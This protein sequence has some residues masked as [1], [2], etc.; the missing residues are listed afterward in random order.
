MEDQKKMFLAPKN[1]IEK[2]AIN[3]LKTPVVGFDT[4]SIVKDSH[5]KIWLN[6]K[7]G[8]R[9]ALGELYDEYIELLYSYGMSISKDRAHVMDCI[10]D[11]FIDLFK[12]RR[13]LAMT[14]NIKYYLFK[15]LKRKIN[16]KYFR[17]IIPL[18]MEIQD[19]KNYKNKNYSKSHEETIIA[20]E[21]TSRRTNNLIVGINSLTKKQR[22]ILYLRFNKEKNYN[23]I[24]EIMEVSLETSRT[25]LYRAIKKLRKNVS[26]F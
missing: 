7:N 11:L 26:Y 23:E 5:S 16:R 3:K 20:N 6:L 9:A 15:S 10:Q 17:K 2:K 1:K 19:S 22:K 12:Y 13:N 18:S 4:L 14:D 25:T 21:V 24:S 8:D